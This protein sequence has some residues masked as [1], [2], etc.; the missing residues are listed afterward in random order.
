VS[1]IDA[2]MALLDRVL[3][4]RSGPVQPDDPIA[5]MVSRTTGRLHPEGDYRR[6]LRGQIV[7][8]YVAMREGMVVAPVR[9]REMGVIGRSVLYATFGLAVSVSAVGAA[10]TGSLPGD[11]LYGVKR[12]VEE[13]R[14]E[15]APPSVRP[16]LVAMALDERLSEVERLAVAQRW[17]EVAA[18]SAEADAAEQR[19]VAMTGTLSPGE[20]ANLK[21][22]H[23]VLTSMLA[24]AP[25]AA[26]VGLLHAIEVSSSDHAAAL[27]A[28]GS[29]GGQANGGGQADGSGQGTG[30]GGAVATGTPSPVPT[31]KP[32]KPPHATP[33]PSP[34]T[35]TLAAHPTRSPSPSGDAQTP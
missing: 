15:V 25:A 20:Q 21:H 31:P 11:P 16:T 4:R 13:L 27:S 18:A 10:S 5:R 24:T 3:A 30:Q 29:G 28:V 35:R 22:H 7:N 12:Q 8:Q 9:R 19:L 33:R 23:D 2:P 17:G 14:I 34:D 1:L 32:T 6:R 26:Q